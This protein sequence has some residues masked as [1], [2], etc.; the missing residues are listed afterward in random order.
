M[1]AC[2]IPTMEHSSSTVPIASKAKSD[3][4]RRSP[5]SNCEVPVSPVRV[6]G[7]FLSVNLP[8]CRPPVVVS[9]CWCAVSVALEKDRMEDRNELLL[10]VV[11]VVLVESVCNDCG[12][13]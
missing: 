5:V 7:T 6:Y 2:A 10:V 11:V 3:L 12:S 4:R 9:F 13:F 1:V 8:P